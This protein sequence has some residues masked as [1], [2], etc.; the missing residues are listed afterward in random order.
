MNPT[1]PELRPGQ[2]PL[3]EDGAVVTAGPLTPPPDSAG[4]PADDRAYHHSLAEDVQGTLKA[5][6]ISRDKIEDAR[7]VLKVGDAVEAKIIN[8]DRKNRVIGLSIKSKD[9]QEEKE[10]IKALKE[11]TDATPATTIGDLIKAQMERK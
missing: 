10:A 5:S 7:N 9:V 8:V 3:P 1:D 4:T 2:A 6:E 11:E